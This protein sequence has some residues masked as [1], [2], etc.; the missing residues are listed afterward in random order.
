MDRCPFVAEERG[1]TIDIKNDAWISQTDQLH[2]GEVLDLIRERVG[3]ENA[4]S[5][6]EISRRLA[7][8]KRDV[9]AIVK[10]LVEER[11]VPIGSAVQRPYGYYLI[12]SDDEL[13]RNY[14]HFVRRGVSNLKHARA[15]MN[16]SVVGPI[17]GQLEIEIE[18]K[19]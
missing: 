4:I 14:Q 11:S 6:H 19:R 17:V 10:F 15:Y 5:M 2:I 12:D 8:D 1:V 13:R 3:R 7:I 18:E 16:A 9:Q